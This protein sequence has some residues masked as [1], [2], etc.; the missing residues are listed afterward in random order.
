MA[1][2][3]KV[4]IDKPSTQTPRRVMD[5]HG[6]GT[7]GSKVTV[8]GVVNERGQKPRADVAPDGKWG[9][10]AIAP[11]QPG[12]HEIAVESQGETAKTTFAVLDPAQAKRR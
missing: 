7:P 3:N 12:V 10:H 11:E 2:D 6:E 1:D 8:E 9:A 4:T 5:L